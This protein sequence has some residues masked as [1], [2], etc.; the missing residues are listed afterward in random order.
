MGPPVRKSGVR[1]VAPT[2]YEALRTSSVVEI[3]QT[4]SPSGLHGKT[5]TEFIASTVELQMCR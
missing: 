5:Y 4:D 1:L 2:L 3:R